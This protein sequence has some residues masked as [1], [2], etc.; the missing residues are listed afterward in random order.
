M[1]ISCPILVTMYCWPSVLSGDVSM[2]LEPTD[3]ILPPDPAL[4][5]DLEE[6]G[7]RNQDLRA[8]LNTEARGE[9]LELPDYEGVY[10]NCMKLQS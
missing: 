2:D 1:G 4:L 9:P 3:L 6:L 7:L 8:L 5:P 10:L